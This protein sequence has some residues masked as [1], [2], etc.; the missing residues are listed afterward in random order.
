MTERDFYF[1]DIQETKSL[2][3][4]NHKYGSRRFDIVCLIFIGFG[5]YA[6]YELF[7]TADVFNTGTGFLLCST[8]L[9]LVLAFTNLYVLKCEILLQ[10]YWMNVYRKITSQPSDL[11]KLRDKARKLEDNLYLKRGLIYVGL[12]VTTVLTL[13][14]FVVLNWG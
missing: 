9:L 11:D 2:I 1:K 3:Y 6:N 13:I 5:I 4:D 7:K 12:V 10:G 14:G 8:L